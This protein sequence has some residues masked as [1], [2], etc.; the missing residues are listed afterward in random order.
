L[1][2]NTKNK[3][4]LAQPY[5]SGFE[6]AHDTYQALSSASDGKIYYVL[7]SESLTKAGQLYSLDPETDKIEW[8]ADL[9]E[10][11][12]EIDRNTIPQGKSHVP[13]FEK[14]GK[15]YFG[16]HIGVYE[17]I[18]DMERLP[19][20]PME[21]VENYLGGH[22][23]SWDMENKVMEDL[24]IVP[25]GE[26]VLTMTM[27]TER[28]Q[29]YALTWP[30]GNFLHLDL[31]TS[32]LKNFGPISEKGEAG[33]VGEDYRVLCRSIL[34]SPENGN[35]YYT[36]SD[37][38]IFC[39]SPNSMDGPAK[40]EDVNMRRDFFGSYDPKVPGNMGYNWRRIFWHDEDNVAYGIHGNSNYLFKF[41]PK[42][43]KIELIER[44]SSLPSKRMG[45]YDQF[46]YGYLG[47][48]L[49]PDKETL[50]YL[51]GGPL[52]D[53]P[54]NDGTKQI[55]KGAAKNLENLHLVTYHLSTNT[56]TDHGPAFYEDGSIPT[57][58]NAIAI[59]KDANVFTMARMQKPW[60]EI[61]DLVKIHYPKK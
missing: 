58:V 15:L 60:G 18:D 22:F 46:S 42:N 52:T 35:V 19:V 14:D 53:R 44:L 38:N 50:Y 20:N 61:Q 10:A 47:F 21:G 7:S 30:S 34:V 26:G 24:A 8:L 29:I 4:L 17:M 27:D 2:S 45:M 32:D 12:G 9:S 11:C 41:D 37:G 13:F 25:D 54:P 56:Y 16:T 3:G 6:I 48:D 28:N 40:L 36:T 23:L 51:T 31:N 39:Y 57:Y 55:A 59:A 33:V 5:Y 1:E 49:G 43:S